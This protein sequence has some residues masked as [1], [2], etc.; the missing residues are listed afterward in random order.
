VGVI[1]GES[2]ILSQCNFKVGDQI[3]ILGYDVIRYEPNQIQNLGMPAF[4]GR[5]VFTVTEFLPSTQRVRAKQNSS[6]F[7]SLFSCSEIT[8]TKIYWDGIVVDIGSI[9]YNQS[10]GVNNPL[11][12]ID[13]LPET[14][15]IKTLDPISDTYPDMY[16]SQIFRT[17]RR[18]ELY[19]LS[20][21]PIKPLPTV[22][23]SNANQ[24][25][26]TK[27]IVSGCES[28]KAETS[29]N[30]SKFESPKGTIKRVYLNGLEVDWASS[31]T[32]AVSDVRCDEVSGITVRY[33][34]CEYE[35]GGSVTVSGT[36]STPRGYL[37]GVNAQKN[38][39]FVKVFG[40]LNRGALIEVPAT[41]VS[42]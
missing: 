14:K 38:T 25:A 15:Q 42:Y 32:G 22:G 7:T 10:R 29:R 4:E 1:Q 28:I 31:S 9:V 5:S 36:A 40:E 30:V 27:L 8:G 23:C 2:Q 17:T 20:A 13:Y 24:P 39:M 16:A 3:F 18:S 37:A 19:F 26:G 35:V 12:V 21:L 11:Y 6:S 33:G 41:S 34:A